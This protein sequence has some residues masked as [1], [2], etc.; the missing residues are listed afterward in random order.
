MNKQLKSK[1]VKALRS[2]KYKQ[3]FGTLKQ[4][5][6]TNHRPMYCCLG[7]LRELM[8]APYQKLAA[9]KG[10]TLSKGQ[11]TMAG[12]SYKV[13]GTLVNMNDEIRNT[14][15]EIAGHIEKKL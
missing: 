8:P 1:W 9:R 11:L 2:G 7:V 13:Q 14:F 6:N 12:I 15:E 5:H 10:F 3:G 4:R